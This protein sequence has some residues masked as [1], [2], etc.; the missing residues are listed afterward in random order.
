MTYGDCL[1]G[2]S[3]KR[4]RALNNS[5]HLTLLPIESLHA[6]AFFFPMFAVLGSSYGRG[7]KK[8]NHFNLPHESVTNF[9]GR[10]RD[11][12]IQEKREN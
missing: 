4:V 8:G 5:S 1:D 10:R 6:H 2:S 7:G 12:H 11:S 9:V 3:V